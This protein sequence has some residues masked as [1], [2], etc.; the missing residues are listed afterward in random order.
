MQASVERA[1]VRR[2]ARA[3]TRRL[4]SD[5]ARLTLGA[6]EVAT[7][8]IR[9]VLGKR[10]APE[11]IGWL[12]ETVRRRLASGD[13]FRSIDY[14]ITNR[15]V[16]ARGAGELAAVDSVLHHVFRHVL[17]CVPEPYNAPRRASTAR[18]LVEQALENPLNGRPHELDRRWCDE[19]GI[20]LTT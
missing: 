17:W 14:D 4:G 1:I 8:T 19:N 10:N 18:K 9:L 11:Q 2:E 15:H 5:E 13:S 20:S 12:D 16:A 3:A 6:V 7:N